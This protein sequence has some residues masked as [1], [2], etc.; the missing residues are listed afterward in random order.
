MSFL[1]ERGGCRA[2][3]GCGELVHDLDDFHQW[4]PSCEVGVRGE[5]ECVVDGFV[6]HF[7]ACPLDVLVQEPVVLL[8]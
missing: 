2:F 3:V 5:L 6:K 4:I 1:E 7:V 8:T